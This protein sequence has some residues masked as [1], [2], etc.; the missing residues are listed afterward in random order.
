MVWD[1]IDLFK[2]VGSRRGSG[3]LGRMMKKLR[4]IT[5]GRKADAKIVCLLLSPKVVVAKAYAPA[6]MS[7]APPVPLPQDAKLKGP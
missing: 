6:P 2:A 4:S 1:G 5:T 7:P 3:F